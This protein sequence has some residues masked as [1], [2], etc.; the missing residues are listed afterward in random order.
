[1]KK[2]LFFIFLSSFS[3]FSF[4]QSQEATIK[5][6]PP[7]KYPQSAL[8]AGMEGSN[9]VR[10]QISE[11][12]VVT[13]AEIVISSGLE[14]LDTAA[15]IASKGCIFNPKLRNGLPT[16]AYFNIPYK[17]SI[18]RK[19]KSQ[20]IP[21]NSIYKTTI[22]NT[23]A[24]YKAKFS[25]FSIGEIKS[26]IINPQCRGLST[27]I[28]PTPTGKYIQLAFNQELRKAGLFAYGKNVITGQILNLD[29][30]TFHP[31]SNGF[32]YIKL[33]LSSPISPIKVVKSK[34]VEFPV[35]LSAKNSCNNA[36]DAFQ[37]L[38]QQLILEFIQS[39]DLKNIY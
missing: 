28:I 35:E 1:V 24:L 32:W 22:Q 5:N 3:V 12:G 16:V 6:C 31:V 25:P 37:V 21:S 8:T 17:W 39:D 7:P 18:E 23:D 9:T 15:I 13:S 36:S 20:F 27:P 11:E 30:S 38:I 33:E 26:D 14:S 19:D 4:C 29:V 2:H 10:I 34:K